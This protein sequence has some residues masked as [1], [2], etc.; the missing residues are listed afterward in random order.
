[1]IVTLAVIAGG[2]PAVAIEQ[3]DDFRSLSVRVPEPVRSE[4]D[5]ALRAWHADY[6]DPA[7]AHAY[8]RTAW[9]RAASVGERAW[10]NAEFDAMLAFADS[11]GWLDEAKEHVR[12]HVDTS[13]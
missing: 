1:M 8:L 3:P 4:L 11:R 13:G 6:A 5:A 2:L 7:G 9:L 10:L 12:A